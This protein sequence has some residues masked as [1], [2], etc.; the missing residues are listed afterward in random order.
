MIGFLSASGEF[1]KCRNM[2]HGRLA[3]KILNDLYLYETEAE[4][5]L[6]L[7]RGWIVLTGGYASLDLM[8]KNVITDQQIEWYNKNMVKLTKYKREDF[9]RMVVNKKYI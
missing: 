3:I 7:N 5:D 8:H 9:N 2:G 6:L 1:H 4:D